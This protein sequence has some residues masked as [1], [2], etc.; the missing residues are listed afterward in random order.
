MVKMPMYEIKSDD[1][2]LGKDERL[3]SFF[4]NYY[5]RWFEM[6]ITKIESV[7]KDYPNF[8]DT[9]ISTDVRRAEEIFRSK[10]PNRTILKV[11]ELPSY[12]G[13][14]LDAPHKFEE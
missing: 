8:F 1:K 11:G 6:Q 4:D 3:K 13:L 2:N 5:R 12:Q 14:I 9:Y 7:D 10:Y